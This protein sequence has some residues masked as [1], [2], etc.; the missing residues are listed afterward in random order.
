MAHSFYVLKPYCSGVRATSVDNTGTNSKKITSI[1]GNPAGDRGI[2]ANDAS[3]MS[4]TVPAG[5]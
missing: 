5:G 1:N 4:G 2:M 3:P